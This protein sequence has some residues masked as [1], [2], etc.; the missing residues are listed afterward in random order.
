M[1]VNYHGIYIINV[2]KHNLTK[3]ASNK[4]CHFNPR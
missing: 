2:I 4:L 3:N 1:A